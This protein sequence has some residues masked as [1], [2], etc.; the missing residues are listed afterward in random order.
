[1]GWFTENRRH[2]TSIEKEM[3]KLELLIM[4]TDSLSKAH[5]PFFSKIIDFLEIIKSTLYFITQG[6]NSSYSQEDY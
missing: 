3:S 4:S 5:M 1:M 2:S 6:S